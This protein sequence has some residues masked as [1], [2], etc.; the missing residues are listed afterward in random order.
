MSTEPVAERTF[1]PGRGWRD[2]IATARLIEAGVDRH[3][4]ATTSAFMVARA[5]I[6]GGERSAFGADGAR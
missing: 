4:G 3:R 1:L 2:A 6:P 5:A